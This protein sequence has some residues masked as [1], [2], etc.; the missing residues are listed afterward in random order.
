MLV[1]SNSKII[2]VKLMM[3]PPF[4]QCENFDEEENQSTII[5]L[6]MKII[7]LIRV[8]KVALKNTAS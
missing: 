7:N 6:L 1:Q 2:R 3:N 4:Q 5:M 8:Q